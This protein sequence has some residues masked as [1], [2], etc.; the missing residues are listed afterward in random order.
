MN[1]MKLFLFALATFNVGLYG[2][3]AILAGYNTNQIYDGGLQHSVD[4]ETI[5]SPLFLETTLLACMIGGA[6]IVFGF[7][8]LNEWTE[9]TRAIALAMGLLA[10][11]MEFLALGYGSKQWQLDTIVEDADLDA[12]LQF[13]GA[14][15]TAATLTQLL[16]VSAL[17]HFPL[18]NEAED[19]SPKQ[20]H[21]GEMTDEHIEDV[22]NV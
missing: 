22:E 7:F 5:I 16:W 20:V 12:R 3:R 9:T 8:H 11:F 14:A 1:N 13:L 17:F 15:S 10:C 2:A 18:D 19:V 6:A 21:E 4:D